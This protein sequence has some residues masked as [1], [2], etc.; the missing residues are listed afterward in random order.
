[1]IKIKY[2]ILLLVPAILLAQGSFRRQKIDRVAV[3][4]ESQITMEDTVRMDTLTADSVPYANSSNDIVSSTISQSELEQLEG[5]SVN[6]QNELDLKLYK[7]LPQNY[8]FVGQSD[9]NASGVSMSGEASILDTG[10]LTLDNDSVIGKLL[11]G[12]TS[13]AGTITASDSILSSIQKLDGNVATKEPLLTKGDLTEAT[14]SVLT[15]LGGT[16]AVIGTGTSIQVQQATT[17]TD[18]YISSVDWNIFNGK[19][20]TISGTANEI[21]FISNVIGIADNPIIPGNES[22]TIPAG[23]T[24]DRPVGVVGMLR[25]NTDLSAF[26]GFD[27]GWNPIAGGGGGGGLDMWTTSTSYV[28]DDIVWSGNLIYKALSA[29]TSGATFEADF[30]LGYWVSMVDAIPL[31]GKGSLLTSD[32]LDNG[33]FTACADGETI[34]WDASETNGFKCSPL[35]TEAITNWKNAGPVVIEAAT[36]NPTKG[37]TSTDRLNWR[38]IGDS[39]QIQVQFRQT[40]AGS[41]GSGIYLFKLPTVCGTGSSQCQID[42]SK[43]DTAAPAYSKNVGSGMISSNLATQIYT[44]VWVNGTDSLSMSGTNEASRYNVDNG[45][46][47]LAASD[48]RLSFTATVPILGWSSNNSVTSFDCD[49]LECVNEFSA[50]VDNDDSPVDTPSII[51]TNVDWLDPSTPITRNGEGST[52]LNLVSG[53]N[54]NEMACTV[55]AVNGSSNF[56]ANIG[57]YTSSSI[58]VKT[59]QDAGSATDSNY[60]ITCQRQGSDYNQYNQRFVKVNNEPTEE[61]IFSAMAG[62]SSNNAAVLYPNTVTTNTFSELATITHDSTNGL[63]LVALQKIVVSASA[64]A[65]ATGAS[66][67]VHTGWTYNADATQ[68]DTSI[69][70]LPSGVKIGSVA[71]VPD[72]TSAN[73]LSGNPIVKILN[74]GDSMAFQGDLNAVGSST[75]DNVGGYIS[76]RP[77]NKSA[78]ITGDIAELTETVKSTGA[79]NPVMY[80]AHLTAS[81]GAV[82][83]EVGNFINGSTCT[84]ATG[85][86]TCDIS[87][88]NFSSTPNCWGIADDSNESFVTQI[89]AASST[90][91][92][93]RIRDNGGSFALVNRNVNLFCHGVK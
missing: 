82:S 41:P 64:S 11:T 56:W 81:T 10:A 8:I 78:F 37:S 24:G 15:I 88:A 84:Y 46:Y 79:T 2:I 42:T 55:T 77:F 20:D 1:M 53:L 57:T 26:E 7:A 91:V 40:S 89:T 47:G 93:I 36:T 25:Y 16:N 72:G 5:I 38:R 12:F 63:R 14:S 30:A 31:L 80:S 73:G 18:G 3:S 69:L 43:L 83:R 49:N 59:D 65:Y 4:T 50:Y 27:G 66:G 22:I 90:S 33:E 32:G 76:A 58:Q 85:I 67:T 61:I 54:A 70:S 62:Y 51:S 28:V 74:V 44:Q 39:M 52:T 68:L 35:A 60:T 75:D 19:Q 17:S 13:G 21:D 6:V 92:T 71:K 86:Y 23:A 9:G 29:H 45:T 87:D 34:V 48:Y